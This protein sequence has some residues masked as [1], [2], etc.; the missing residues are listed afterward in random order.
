MLT[1]KIIRGKLYNTE[2]A[3]YL[4]SYMYGAPSDF[5]YTEEYLYRKKTGEYFLAGSGGPLSKYRKDCRPNGW[6]W[7]SEIIPM[8]LEAAKDWV[9]E[10]LDAEEYIDIFGE[11]EE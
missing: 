4:G 5:R 7:G 6:G 11:P 9:E 8:S 1:K 10:Y 3:E 2:T